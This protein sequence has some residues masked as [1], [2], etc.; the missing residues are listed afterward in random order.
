MRSR[1]TH[2]QKVLRELIQVAM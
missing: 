2:L 1:S